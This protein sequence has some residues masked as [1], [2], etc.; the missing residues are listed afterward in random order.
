VSKRVKIIAVCIVIAI[1]G[2]MGLRIAV[3][4]A[5]ANKIREKLSRIS[6][7]YGIE[8]S[9]GDVKTDF[10]SLSL[11]NLKFE[12][13]SSTIKIDDISAKVSLKEIAKGK[14]NVDTIYIRGLILDLKAQDVKAL[15][16]KKRSK[17]GQ[18]NMP[19]TTGNSPIQSASIVDKIKE[20]VRHIIIKSGTLHATHEESTIDANALS[21]KIIPG[22]L[23]SLTLGS[24][25]ISNPK[26]TMPITA[27]TMNVA[28]MAVYPPIAL[29]TITVEDGSIAPMENLVL[30]SISGTI[31]P[32]INGREFKVDLAGSYGGADKQLWT[33]KGDSNIR[34]KEG[35]LRLHVEKF[36]LEKIAK[37]LRNTPI[38]KPKGTTMNADIHLSH[39]NGESHISGNANLSKVNLFHIALARTI[40]HDVTLSIDGEAHYTGRKIDIKRADIDLNGLKI[41]ANAFAD[42]STDKPIYHLSAYTE[43]A[44]CQTI[45][46]AIPPD[47][48]PR[49]KGI[50]LSGTAAPKIDMHID[51]SHLRELTFKPEFDFKHCDITT[52]PPTTNIFD[53]LHPFY[54]SVEFV[55][56]KRREFLVGPD[57]PDFTRVRRISQ[58]LIDTVITT[59]DPGFYSHKGFMLKLIRI[60]L[61][62]NLEAGHF[63]IGASTIT[64]QLVKNLFL[65][66]EKT[67]SR[68]LQEMVLSWYVDKIV[69]KRRIMEIYLNI[70]EYGPNIYGIH[71]AAKHFFN[72][73]PGSLRPIQAAYL[74]SIIPSP[75]SRYEHYCKGVLPSEWVRQINRI[76]R[77]RDRRTQRRLRATEPSPDPLDGAVAAATADATTAGLPPSRS[78]N[79]SANVGQANV[80]HA[81]SD[82][83]GNDAPSPSINSSP[84]TGDYSAL[85]SDS[86]EAIAKAKPLAEIPITENV[87]FSRKE[88]EFDNTESCL[89]SIDALKKQWTMAYRQRIKEATE[90][91]R[92]QSIKVP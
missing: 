81:P 73:R 50:G 72:R 12:F 89:A 67:L 66:G 78:I 20:R 18:I 30:S 55:P 33:L 46:D 15:A 70:A 31:L 79:I 63:T 3:K 1:I 74:A 80:D 69:P 54:H 23:S 34:S 75:R 16:S 61:I 52:M 22:E 7:T 91:A 17:D 24:L 36:E 84:A 86:D 32:Q 58:N 2:V 26:L 10:K 28:G 43:P 44:P 76:R 65:S 68:K 19:A 5:A 14:K 9:L 8:S 6:K 83:T 38:V 42:K 77:R 35:D 4:R 47:L 25:K 92:G 59:E 29:P 87:R 53:L 64:M 71:R 49:L 85:K 62:K 45:L 13:G 39:K 90:R 56:G 48:I 60:A 11:R 21:A 41:H 27:K 57:N 51:Y 40:V 82:L 37:Y 88:F